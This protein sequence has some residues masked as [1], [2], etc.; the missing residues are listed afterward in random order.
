MTSLPIA[1]YTFLR[2]VLAREDGQD[3]VEY[4]LIFAM[5]SLGSVSGMGFLASGINTEFAAVATTL[6]SNV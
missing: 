4:A 5:I 1:I 6:T 2:N 3:L